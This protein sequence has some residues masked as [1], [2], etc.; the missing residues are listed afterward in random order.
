MTLGV[1]PAE[2]R[3]ALIAQGYQLAL[4]SPE[5]STRFFR[6]E[7]ERMAKIVKAANV[8]LD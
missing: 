3:D 5:A 7:M 8:K 1:S 4:M 2:G 6:S